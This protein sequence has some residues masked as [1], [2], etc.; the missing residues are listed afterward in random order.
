MKRGL[1]E[2]QPDERDIKLSSVYEAPDYPQT[3][4]TR[5]RNWGMLGNDKWGDCYW[6]SAA[7]E[8][9]AQAYTVGRLPNFDTGNVLDSYAV[10]LGLYGRQGLEANPSK[11][12]GTEP[13]AGAKARQRQGVNDARARGHRIGAYV[14]ENDL[15]KLLPSLY[16][17]RACTLCLELPQSAEEDFDS[18]VWDYK[19]GSPIVGGHAVAGVAAE[20]GELIAVSW[21][22]EVRLTNEFLQ[23]YLQTAMFYVSGAVLDGS[24]KSPTGLD[25]AALR[26]ALKSA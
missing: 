1:L 6:A 5:G 17:F 3:F 18:G 10:Y 14:F 8:V 9:M 26:A 21:G 22:Q 2:L 25:A 24:G 20:K 16:T 15:S 13:R 12:Q 4:G 19:P 11:D 7:H 23:H